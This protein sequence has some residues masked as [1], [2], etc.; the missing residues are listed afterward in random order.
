MSD[1]KTTGATI[2]KNEDNM[3]P[4]SLCHIIVYI[5]LLFSVASQKDKRR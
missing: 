3:K 5:H 4:R 1:G 2:N